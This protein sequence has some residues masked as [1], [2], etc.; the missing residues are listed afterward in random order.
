VRT[1]VVDGVDFPLVVD[2]SEWPLLRADQKRFLSRNVVEVT[3]VD[4]RTGVVE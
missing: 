2:D 4:E 3:G 1:P